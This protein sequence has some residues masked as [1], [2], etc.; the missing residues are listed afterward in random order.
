MSPGSPCS[1]ICAAKQR[2]SSGNTSS[3]KGKDYQT[4]ERGK[5]PKDR[6]GDNVPQGGIPQESG[7]WCSIVLGG[8]IAGVGAVVYAL[9]K[10]FR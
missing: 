2:S 4:S 5:N 9:A 10:I 8:G 6:W 7:G 3:G 1:S